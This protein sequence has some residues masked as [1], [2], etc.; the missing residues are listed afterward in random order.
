MSDCRTCKHNTYRNLKDCDYVSCGHPVTLRKQ[1][2]PE[3]RDPAW[4]NAMTADI[5]ISQMESLQ[6][7]ECEAWEA[8]Q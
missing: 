2:K 5:K 8:I 3:A 1:P 4:V 6:L 7:L